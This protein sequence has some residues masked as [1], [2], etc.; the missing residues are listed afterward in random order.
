MNKNGTG[1]EVFAKGLRNTIGYAFHPQTQELW[2]MDH[3]M[4]WLGDDQPEEELNHLVRAPIMAGLGL[5]ARV[6]ST[7]PSRGRKTN[8]Q[9]GTSF[10]KR[11]IL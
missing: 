9:P 10:K 11:F 7:S 5:L 3:G 8:L 4:D 2:G 6:L 1:K